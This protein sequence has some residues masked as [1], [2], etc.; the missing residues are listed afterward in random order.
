VLASGHTI[1][2][3]KLLDEVDF[4]IEPLNQEDKCK[5]ILYNSNGISF[6]NEMPLRI[7]EVHDISRRRGNDSECAVD[8]RHG[9][10]VLE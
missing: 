6:N 9:D 2:N 8:I 5:E 7:L 3:L 4:G 1:F 10:E